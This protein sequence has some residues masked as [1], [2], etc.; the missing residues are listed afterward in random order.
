MCIINNRY[1]SYAKAWR[2]KIIWYFRSSLSYIVF[3]S[4]YLISLSPYVSLSFF[5]SL[6]QSHEPFCSYLLSSFYKNSK[7]TLAATSPPSPAHLFRR[8]LLI[9]QP[10]MA[11]K[12]WLDGSAGARLKVAVLIRFQVLGQLELY[13]TNSYNHQL[14]NPSKYFHLVLIN[15]YFDHRIL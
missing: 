7:A 5:L 4:L 9:G 1:K 14:L 8:K 3:S 15:Y 13:F 6:S 2:I 12:L 11:P 10:I